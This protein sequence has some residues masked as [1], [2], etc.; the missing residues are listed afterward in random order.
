MDPRSSMATPAESES[1]SAPRASPRGDRWGRGALLAIALP[2]ITLVVLLLLWDWAVVHFQIPSTLLARPMDVAA[3]LAY[4]LK[5]GTLVVH[6]WVTLQEV[7]YGFALGA[8]AGFVLGAVV[9]ESTWTRLALYKLLGEFQMIP[10][11]AI[12]PLF[13]IWLGYGV[14][15]KVAFTASITF[16]PVV[17]NTIAGLRSVDSDVLDLRRVFRATPWQSFYRLK[18]KCALPYLFGS[19]EVAMVLS[20]I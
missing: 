19:L 8:F 13:I 16:F 10:K 2:S 5:S 15:S 17:I 6:T 1:I 4:G 11:V 9:D 14:S 18:L 3:E 12:A 20:V 7:F